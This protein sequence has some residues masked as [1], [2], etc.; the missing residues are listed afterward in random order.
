LSANFCF[1]FLLNTLS[2]V[3][4]Y[5]MHFRGVAAVVWWTLTAPFVAVYTLVTNHPQ[6]FTIMFGSLAITAWAAVTLVSIGKARQGEWSALVPILLGIPLYIA[7]ALALVLAL[8]F[9]AYRAADV[10]ARAVATAAGEEDV[11][12]EI[13]IEKS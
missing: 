8:V 12:P 1:Y 5:K 13:V 10:Y 6:F 7:L 2:S 3:L 9:I 11:V 4:I